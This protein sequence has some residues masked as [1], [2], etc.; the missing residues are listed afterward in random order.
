[1][2]DIVFMHGYD[3]GKKNWDSVVWGIT[4]DKPG[5]VPT[6]I[7]VALEQNAEI[8]VLNAAD[9][10]GPKM[11][12][13]FEKRSLKGFNCF[14]GMTDEEIR[15]KISYQIIDFVDE[16][17]RP[18]N[19]KEEAL[20]FKSLFPRDVDVA[21]TVVTSLDHVFRAFKEFY[22]AFAGCPTILLHLSL[23]AALTPYGVGPEENGMERVVVIEPP[24]A[25]E[26]KEVLE[27]IFSPKNF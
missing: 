13:L 25:E 8:I 16:E 15:K 14:K 19:T 20:V 18:K 23:R 27:R 21:I 26:N 10:S 4:P 3:P 24:L 22:L 7:L 9:G 5:R 2:K 6:A 12:E 11:M 1:M 17:S